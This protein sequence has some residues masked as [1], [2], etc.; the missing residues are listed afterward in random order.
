MTY[1]GNGDTLT[2]AQKLCNG[3]GRCLEVCPHEVLA[4]ADGKARITDRAACIECGACA[5]NCEPG[6]LTVRAG[7][8]CASAVI[9]GMIRGTGPQCGCSGSDGVQRG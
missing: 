2:L 3:C 7:G 6:A 5:N 9:L 8:G 4:M 1:F